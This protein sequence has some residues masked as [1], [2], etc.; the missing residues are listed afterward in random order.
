MSA[1]ESSRHNMS[2]KGKATAEDLKMFH[3]LDSGDSGGGDPSDL[4]GVHEN[5]SS[6][7]DSTAS[8]CPALSFS[9]GYSL[10]LPILFSLLL[11]LLLLLVVVVVVVVVV[12]YN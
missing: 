2:K 6:E 8:H 3:N 4:S 12:G 10:I 7:S 11:L 1:M 5:T 9:L